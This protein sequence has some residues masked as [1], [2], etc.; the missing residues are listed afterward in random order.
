MTGI[1]FTANRIETGAAVWLTDDLSW[2]EDAARAF[3]FTDDLAEN[4]R[5][6]VELAE[7]RDEI[8]AA[9]E[10]P[11]DKVTTRPS[12]REAIRAARGPSVTPPADL[13]P[14][15]LRPADLRPGDLRPADLRPADLR[16]CRPGT[17]MTRSTMTSSGAG[18]PSSVTRSS[19]G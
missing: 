4:A 9:Y 18:R 3:R 16:P 8:I 14:G 2:T 10:M 19:G 1:R 17:A 15:D 6:A 11:E 13:R 12:A 7:G 5:L